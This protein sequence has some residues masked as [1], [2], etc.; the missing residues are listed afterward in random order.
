MNTVP[1]PF[2]RPFDK[3][4]IQLTYKDDDSCTRGRGMFLNGRHH[5][6]AKATGTLRFLVLR[7]CLHAT[8]SISKLTLS[9]C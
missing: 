2:L 9:S 6:S 4:F 3:K 5:Q 8:K 1:F 7:H